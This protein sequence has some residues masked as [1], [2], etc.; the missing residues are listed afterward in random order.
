MGTPNR[1]IFAV[2]YNPEYKESPRDLVPI[3]SDPT[4]VFTYVIMPADRTLS[5]PDDEYRTWMRDIMHL[6]DPLACDLTTTT[7]MD[8]LKECSL[9]NVSTD[10]KLESLTVIV[11][12]F[13]FYSSN[14]LSNGVKRD[15]E[16]EMTWPQW[17][18][19][20]VDNHRKIP[21]TFY[22]FREI[23]LKDSPCDGS[24]IDGTNTADEFKRRPYEDRKKY[25]NQC[26][27]HITQSPACQVCGHPPSEPNSFRCPGCYEGT[28]AICSKDIAV[29]YYSFSGP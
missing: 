21:I 16:K 29:Y 1:T 2:A 27:P 4:H 19:S 6:D 3:D 5:V 9:F 25:C 18:Q 23:R 13:F 7:L 22:I 11:V 8:A 17:C 14:G 24:S 15:D 12:V 10:G 28:C 20:R 26:T